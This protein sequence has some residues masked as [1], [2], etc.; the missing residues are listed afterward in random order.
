LGGRLK[1]VVG[2]VKWV[3]GWVKWQIEVVLWGFFWTSGWIYGSFVDFGRVKKG[4]LLGSVSLL[5][6]VRNPLTDPRGMWV[7]GFSANCGY[8]NF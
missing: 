7:G 2:R 3:G 1:W 5:A 6:R 4:K 8:L